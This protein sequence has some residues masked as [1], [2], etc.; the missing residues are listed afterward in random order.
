[1]RVQSRCAGCPQLPEVAG[2]LCSVVVCCVS[3]FRAL[4]P[5]SHPDTCCWSQLVACKSIM[6]C[7]EGHEGCERYRVW[8]HTQ[9]LVVGAVT[10]VPL[11]GLQPIASVP[12]SCI[13]HTRTHVLLSCVS[14]LCSRPPAVLGVHNI[15]PEV[16][17]TSNTLQVT[18]TR[19][20]HSSLCQ[21][22]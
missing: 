6:C 22:P 11:P 17:S 9:I 16:D 10:S 19:A 12:H 21:C 8:Q 7:F 14:Q 3:G 15:Q 1:M 5:L 4:H 13:H 2:Q 18:H 20:H